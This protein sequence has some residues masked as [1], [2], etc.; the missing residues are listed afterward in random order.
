[1][2][3]KESIKILMLK[4]NITI[5]SLANK[6]TVATGRQYTRQSLSKKISRSSLKFDEIE[7]I[8]KLLGYKIVF[9]EV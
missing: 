2:S 8:A 3:S 4:K 7:D 6:L 5:T 9:E 1:M